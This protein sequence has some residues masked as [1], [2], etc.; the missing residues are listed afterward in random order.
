[1]FKDWNEL[2]AINLRSMFL[3]YNQCLWSPKWR[4]CAWYNHYVISLFMVCSR[5]V[6]FSCTVICSTNKLPEYNWIISERAMNNSYKRT[7]I[8]GKGQVR[9][10]KDYM[11]LRLIMFDWSDTVFRRRN[12]T[13]RRISNTVLQPE[14]H[15][16]S[17]NKLSWDQLKRELMKW[18]L[19]PYLFKGQFTIF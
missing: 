16:W 7:L 13:R 18:F 2:C 3:L 11:N 14:V 6:V 9:M 4:R 1:M 17:K 10:F 5:L 8:K 12:V 19:F 15:W